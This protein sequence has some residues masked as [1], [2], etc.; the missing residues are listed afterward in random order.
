VT[1]TPSGTPIT[2]EHIGYRVRCVT[3]GRAGDIDDLAPGGVL[4]I[5]HDAGTWCKVPASE[6]QPLEFYWGRKP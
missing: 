4:V 2:A 6:V 3:C 1:V 5:R